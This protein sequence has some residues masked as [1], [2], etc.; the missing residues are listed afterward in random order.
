MKC[1]LTILFLFMQLVSFSQQKLKGKPKTLEQTFQYLNLMFDDTSK[2]TFMTL[3]E[4]IAVSRLHFGFGM[5]L[6]N[7]WGLWR[8]SQLHQYFDSIGVFHA[9]DM[10]GIILTSYHRY[11]NKRPI[12]LDSQINYYRSFWKKMNVDGFSSS[13]M[14][15]VKTE[16]TKLISYY[17][18]GDTILIGVSTTYRKWFTNYYSSA[19]AIAIVKTHAID[20]MQ[21]EIIS[22]IVPK[23]QKP[24]QKVGD[25]IYV[26]PYFCDL[27]PPKGW[28]YK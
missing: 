24:E 27:V 3:P 12:Q 18:V 7:S 1:L 19:K 4:D 20:S 28:S 23:K 9:D 26:R 15:F 11:L 17:P 16:P 5:Y 2:Y 6:R 13:D 21:V 8:H 25:I 22:M 10:S 14:G